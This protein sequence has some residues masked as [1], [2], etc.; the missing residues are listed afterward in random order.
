MKIAVKISYYPLSEHY[1]QIIHDFIT[2]LATH[3]EIDLRPGA[4]SSII[5]GRYEDIFQVLHEEVR[6]FMEKYPAVLHLKIA[7]SCPV[8]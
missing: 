5:V 6:E 7:N 1:N 8:E 4:M 3:Q 2:R